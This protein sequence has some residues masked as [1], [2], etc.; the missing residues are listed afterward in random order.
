MCDGSTIVNVRSDVRFTAVAVFVALIALVHCGGGNP[1]EADVGPLPQVDLSTLDP[2]LA[3]RLAKAVTNLRSEPENP[4][5]N[6]DVAM[7]LHAYQQF[8][9]A[10]QFY[11]RAQALEP[12]GLQWPYYLGV[13]H[14]SQGRYDEAIVSFNSVL[15]I[16][17]TFVPA[18]KRRARALLDYRE[19]DES[20]RIYRALVANEPNDAEIR[21]G[22]GRVHAALGNSEDAVVHLTRAV[23]ILTNYGEAHYALALAYRDLGDEENSANHLQLYEAD[24]FSAPTGSDLLMTAVSSLNISAVEYLKVGVEAEEAGRI[25]EA[26]DHHLRALQLD[27]TL[28]PAHVNLVLLYATNGEPDSAKFHYEKAL[29]LNP[30]SATLHY[31]YGMFAFDGGNYNQAA[32]SFERALEI[33]PDYAFANHDLGQLH[34]Q[35]GRIDDAIRYYRR[36]VENR[37][38]YGLAHFNLGRTMMR[39]GRM[40]DAIREFRLALREETS[41]TPTCLATLASAYARLGKM[42]EAA[43][44]FKLARQAAE[45]YGQDALAEEIDNE[46]NRLAAHREP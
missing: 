17:P 2:D 44:T 25:P 1:P 24:R 39:K 13:I 10:V 31:Y 9:L 19:L 27:P 35:A 18:K 23:E 12:A 5:F 11:Q 22:L 16:D 14:A 38:D 46:I 29:A 3:D 33:N 32:A 43:D 30:N 37:P 34:E 41:L 6:G 20:L 45:R 4:S 36:A 15:A 21:N 40:A 26:I 7:M 8:E 42:A 28:H